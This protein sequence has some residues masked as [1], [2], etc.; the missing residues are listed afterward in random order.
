MTKVDQIKQLQQE[1]AELRSKLELKTKELAQLQNKPIAPLDSSAS[2]DKKIMLFRSLFRG[3]EDVYA[4]RFE[5]MK[6]GKSGY[7]KACRNEWVRGKCE[8]PHIKC[9]DCTNKEYLPGTN[10][11]VRFHLTGVEANKRSNGVSKSF[12]VGVYPMLSN[13]TCW[14]LAIDFDKKKWMEDVRA[15]LDT[16]QEENIPAYLER[17]RSGNGGHVWIFF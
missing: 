4:R 10:E 12:V 11:V 17:S 8:K 2:A 9:A 1:I 5:S 15:F 13:E 16:C 14:F 7:Q 3:R 6:T